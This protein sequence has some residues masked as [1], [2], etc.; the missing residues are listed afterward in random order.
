MQQPDGK[1]NRWKQRGSRS[2]ELQS[3]SGGAKWTGT[4]FLLSSCL[5]C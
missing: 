5:V 1:V 3:L 2:N 4:K